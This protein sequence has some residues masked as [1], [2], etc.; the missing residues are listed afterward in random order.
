VFK[1]NLKAKLERIFRFKKTSFNAPSDQFEQDILFV[2]VDQVSSR[3][4]EGEESARVWGSL[5]IYSQMDKFPYGFLAKQIEKANFDDTR[6]LFFYDF[7]ED[8][9]G[10]PARMMNLS[11]RRLKFLYLYKGQ[12]DPNQGELTSVD[13]GG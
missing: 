11:E 5:T 1:N 10:S 4:R 2:N 13:F 12:Y 7:E 3:I 6:E 8:P 9:A